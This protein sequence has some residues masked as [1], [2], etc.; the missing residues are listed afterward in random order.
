MDLPM[1]PEN[2]PY[3]R[4]PRVQP[5]TKTSDA[6][7]VLHIQSTLTDIVM[8][9]STEQAF[10]SNVL[11][12]F[13]HL[14]LPRR[15]STQPRALLNLEIA[16]YA[17]QVMS[18][19]WAIYSFSN[20][21]FSSTIQSQNLPFNVSLACDPSEAG[22][23]FFVEFAP[24]AKV[25]SSGNYFLQHVRALGETSVLHGYLINSYRKQGDNEFLE[26][27]T[28]NYHAVAPDKESLGY[29]CHRHARSQR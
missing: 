23:S 10:L 24:N 26:T 20:R 1:C 13:G 18:F 8:S 14:A 22:R 29:H 12:L 28:C 21:H 9:N 17:F 5:V 15:T 11:V 2:M 6:D 3:Y 25:F 16:S 4:G 7:N 19:C 27:T